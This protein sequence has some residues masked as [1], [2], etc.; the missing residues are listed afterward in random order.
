MD[1]DTT[2]QVAANSAW[3]VTWLGFSWFTGEAA[4][5]L[6]GRFDGRVALQVPNAEL[7]LFVSACTG[8]A[9]QIPILIGLALAGVLKA[10]FIG[11]S[12]LLVLAAA[13]I[14]RGRYRACWPVSSGPRLGSAAFWFEL[15]PLL[16]LITAWVIRPL[17]PSTG[18]DDISYHLP[19]ARFYLEQGGLV[20]NEYLRY[21]L[22]THSYNLLYSV[23][24]LR[25]GTTMAQWVHGASG[26]LVML[27]TWGVARHW[28][29]WL[30][31]VIATIS[32]LF[33]EMFTDALGN[34]Y[35]DLGLTLFFTA[36]VVVLVLWEEY[37][38]DAWF[39]LS[40]MLAGTMLGIK[41][42]A[43]VLGGLIGLIVIRL[44]RN[45]KQVLLFAGIA[46]LFGCFWYIRSLL[47]SG[48][49]IHPFATEIFGNYIWTKE[50]IA[51]QWNDLGRHGIDK[52]P[53][54][55]LL[56][57]WQLVTNPGSFH[58]APGLV[59]W[60]I[61]LFY[62]G[63]LMFK[64]WST[65]LR[66]LSLA[67]LAYLVFWFS[68]SHVMRYLIPVMPLLALSVASMAKELTNLLRTKLMGW[69]R[70]EEVIGELF[71]TR[72]GQCLVIIPISMFW[73]DTLNEDLKRLPLS[74]IAQD[75]YLVRHRAGYEILQMASSHPAIGKGALLNFQ[76]VS[77]RF[78]YEGELYGDWFGHYPFRQFLASKE[79]GAIGPAS[80][81]YF[82][83][84]LTENG[85]KGLVFSKTRGDR[86]YPE[87]LAE[88][89]PWFE[90]VFS[91]DFGDVLIPRTEVPEQTQLSN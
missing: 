5:A 15:S 41:Y 46:T 61:G 19:V 35:V 87:D 75:Q 50:D 10:G 20:V 1:F 4:L 12:A 59:G 17:G 60:L 26:Y 69:D 3:I 88:F 14:L 33:L 66:L 47:I 44:N 42:S 8:I 85:I 77:D 73:W 30:G 49:P 74:E 63:L 82:W 13:F 16:L 37:R 40:A 54:N 79:S 21:P 58:E 11:A 81:R 38:R 23:A 48:N 56:L 28:F 80:P 29:G 45:L 55:F 86:F 52:T 89:E 51:G 72:I 83:E 78:Y 67:A 9:V 68:T 31:A 2:L 34:A 7:K 18:H 76:F 39:W 6:L 27:G 62:I 25:E 64:R 43:L 71:F 57:P 53:L 91:N 32:L 84:V 24:L 22:H 36:S 90:I 70:S 65:T